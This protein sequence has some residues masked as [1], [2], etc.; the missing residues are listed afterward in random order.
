MKH[1]CASLLPLSCV[2]EK[3]KRS[4]SVAIIRGKPVIRLI[5][6]YIFSGCKKKKISSK[7]KRI[8]CV[9]TE[10]LWLEWGVGSV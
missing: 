4:K 8:G 3:A 6:L 10:M 5:T 2:L 7:K 9:A 1:S